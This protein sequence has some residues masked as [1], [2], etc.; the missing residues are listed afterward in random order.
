MY[1]RQA[2]QMVIIIPLHD[3]HLAGAGQT[4]HPQTNRMWVSDLRYTNL[5]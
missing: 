3:N 2:P 5:T 4:T 1:V